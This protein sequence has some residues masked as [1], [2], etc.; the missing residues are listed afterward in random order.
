MDLFD[1]LKKY[2]QKFKIFFLNFFLKCL[3]QYQKFKNKNILFNLLLFC[4]LKYLFF[5]QMYA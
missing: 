2:F 4:Q 3:I 5:L 1:F